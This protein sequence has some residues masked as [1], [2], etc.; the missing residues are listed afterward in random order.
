MEE[1]LKWD[2]FISLPN[3]SMC[4]R[5]KV[6]NSFV[7]AWMAYFMF[8][9]DFLLCWCDSVQCKWHEPCHLSIHDPDSVMKKKVCVRSVFPSNALLYG[10]TTSFA[11]WQKR[12]RENEADEC[13]RGS[14]RRSEGISRADRGEPGS[15]CFSRPSISLRRSGAFS[16]HV[17]LRSWLASSVWC[18]C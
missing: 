5:R 3:A 12:E 16:S 7:L 13:E 6:E 14:Q 8:L 9:K 10:S 4:Q 18:G 15:Q 11:L 17:L 1:I 2:M